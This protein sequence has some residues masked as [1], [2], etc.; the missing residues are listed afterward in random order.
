MEFYKMTVENN[1]TQIV[2]QQIKNNGPISRREIQV[3]T[4]LSWGTV[5]RAVEHLITE[6]YVV[7]LGKQ[8]LK[9]VGPKT[10]KL[11][12]NPQKHYFFGFDLDNRRLIAIVSDIKGRMV[13]VTERKW[14]HPTRETV[15]STLYEIADY[16]MEKY[17]EN[18]VEGIGFALQGVADVRAGI[19]TYIG[20]I[21]SWND[22][23]LKQLMED[24]YHVNVVVVHDP[25][26]LMKCEIAMGLLKER[27][28]RDVLLIHYGFE[29]ALGMSVA[30]NGQIY[31]GHHGR[32]GEIGYTILGVN[33]DG[34]SKMLEQ[35]VQHRDDHIP[36]EILYDYIARGVA[37]ANSFFNPEIIVL[38]TQN[39]PQQDLLVSSVKERILNSSWDTTVEVAVSDLSYFSKAQGA[40]LFSIENMI[41]TMM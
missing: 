32:A 4:G 18:H 23:P 17:R 33:E 13:D 27:T 9:S 20:K 36:P 12:I 7:V 39:C 11:D 3:N 40:A 1:G 15:L 6:E 26:C 16:Y 41:E 21:E 19:S 35:Y 25:D 38:H 5:S 37:M 28:V 14:T 29:Y 30:M 10:E 34:S 24:R 31:V 22:V 2:F 8:D